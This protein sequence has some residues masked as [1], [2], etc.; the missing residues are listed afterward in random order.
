M[1]KHEIILPPFRLPPPQIPFEQRDLAQRLEQAA[2]KIQRFFRALQQLSLS[3]EPKAPRLSYQKA[4]I[5]VDPASEES[6]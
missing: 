5:I 1:T 4:T 3:N 2:R 6:L